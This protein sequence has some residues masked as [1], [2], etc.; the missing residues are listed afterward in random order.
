MY[1]A[2]TQNRQYIL[3]P[4]TNFAHSFPFYISSHFAFSSKNKKFAHFMFYVSLMGQINAKLNFERRKCMPILSFF[5]VNYLYWRTFNVNFVEN[6]GWH[7]ATSFQ[8]I[9][10]NFQTVEVSIHPIRVS[11][12]I[13]IC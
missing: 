1:V 12:H 9:F 4:D 13:C 11:L 8:Y 10:R 6:F 7:V 2:G 5:Y 3:F